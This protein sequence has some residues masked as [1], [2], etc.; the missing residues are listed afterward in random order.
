MPATHLR[1]SAGILLL[2]LALAGCGGGSGLSPVATNHVD[3][4]KSYAFSPAAVTVPVG[5]TIT[6]TNSDNFTHSVRLLDA[7]EKVIGVMHPGQTVQ[8]TFTRPGF[9]HY[10]CSFHP[11]NMKATVTVKAA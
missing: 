3:L 9:Y 5:T 10:D 4:P 7:G 1:A 11:Q 2:A 6:W 8:F